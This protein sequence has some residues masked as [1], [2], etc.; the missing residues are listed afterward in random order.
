[1]KAVILAA[2]EGKRLRPLTNKIP[3]PMVKVGG[4]PILEYTLTILPKEITEVVLVVGYRK[5]AIQDYFG[6]SFGGR[7]IIYVEQPEMK[8]TGD[9]LLHA[10]PF[11]DHE[12]FLLLYADD[13]YHPEDIAACVKGDAR[14]LV[15]EHQRPERFGVCRIEEDGRVV[16]ILEKRENPPS[17]LV[18]IGVYYLTSRIFEFPPT[19]SEVHGEYFF[20]EQLSA[21]AQEYPI[22]VE[23][24]RFWH[25]IGYP[26]DL[27]GAEHFIKLPVEERVN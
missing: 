16:E 5:E 15:K 4:K 17:N 26:E 9:A 13:L 18:N 3:K 1:M 7:K 21:M 24:A 14:I 22:Y 27:P 12:P 11:L 19:F 25:P 23:R 10:Q 8:G 2:G 20:T 6:D